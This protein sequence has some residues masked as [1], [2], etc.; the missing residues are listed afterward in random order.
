MCL[1][2]QAADIQTADMLNLPVPEVDYHNISVQPTEMQREMVAELG[3]R[4]DKVRNRMVSP[5]KDNM[6]LITGDGRKLALDQ[7]L[8]NPMLPDSP[9]SK[10]SVCCDNV[11]R[12]WE[13][14]KDTRQAQ[15]VFCDL[16]TPKNDG[17]F[18]VYDDI[19]KKL[20]ARGVSPEEVAFIHDANTETRK[21]ELFAK[22]RSGAVRVLIGST[23]KMGAG[24]NVQER[25]IAIHDLDCPWRPSDLEQRRGRLVRQGNTNERVEV[26]RYVTENTF[27][28]YLWQMVEGK[29]RFIGQIMTSKSPVRSAEDVDEQALSYAE[30]KALATGNPLIK[31][32][33]DLD[34]EVARLK[35]LKAD[36]LS[37]KYTLEDNVIKHYPQ[38]IMALEERIAGYEADLTTAHAN[39]PSDKE[40]FSMTVGDAQ[41]SERKLAGEAILAMAEKLSSPEPVPLGKFAGFGLELAF[42]VV[43][44]E[45]QCVI[46][47]KLRH[48]VPLGDDAVGNV[49]RID[50]AIN[51]LESRCDG[52]REQLENIRTQM[53]NAKA[54]ALK[55]FGKEAEL[56]EKSARL[57][58]LD[59]LLNMDEKTVEVLDGGDTDMDELD[60][61]PE[62][63]RSNGQER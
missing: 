7:R 61:E 40:H 30:I 31:E 15:L 46:V 52:C 11:Y 53:D 19:K 36:F 28:S 49:A 45:F 16:S 63:E 13:H 34:V 37:Q 1:F 35:M 14:H 55:P 41:F 22:V 18:N 58:E 60:L 17:S 6:L 12:L 27:D 62:R 9:T 33:M 44:R 38:R 50:N 26:Y 42:D 23:A 2:R 4:A 25:L 48:T 21:A 3:A 57:A 43:S 24:T 8:I 10:V 32:R 39:K 56:T 54:E 20:V 29:Q 59:A 47:G 51:A 5:A